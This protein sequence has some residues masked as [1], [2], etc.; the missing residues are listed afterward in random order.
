[1]RRGGKLVLVQEL[2]T[3]HLEMSL[4]QLDSDCSLLFSE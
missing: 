3:I 1:M 4:S 2:F